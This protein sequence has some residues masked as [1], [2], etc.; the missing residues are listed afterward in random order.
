[1]LEIFNKNNFIYF[2][3]ILIVGPL[4]LY[5]GIKNIQTNE[6]IFTFIEYLGIILILYHSFKAYTKI[7]NNKSA[8]INYFHIFLIGPLLV[9][10]GYYKKDTTNK[11][12]QLVIMAAMATIGY[13]IYK[14]FF[15]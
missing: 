12:F 10:I 1:M 14:L 6:Y 13:N 8:W 15:N 7:M 5:I 2:F 9:I 11:Y 4:F 3:H